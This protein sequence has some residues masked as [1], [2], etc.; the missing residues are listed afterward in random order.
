MKYL[1]Q[2]TFEDGHQIKQPEDDRYSKHD[3]K[4]EYNPSAFRD[5]LDYEVLSAVKRFDLLNK[6]SDYVVFSVD[7]STGEFVVGGR[8][9]RLEDNNSQLTDRKLIYYRTM[10]KDLISGIQR[11]VA[12]NYGYE[13]KNSEGKVIKKI[14]SLYE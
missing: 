13:G 14:V 6:G 8:A 11:C 10:E 1:W 4:L 9:I 2:A 7:L 12:Y 5:I 3:N